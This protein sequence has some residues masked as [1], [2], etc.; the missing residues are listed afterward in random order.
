MAAVRKEVINERKVIP[1]R[2]F[3]SKSH[4]LCNIPLETKK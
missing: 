4:I 3:F 1:L 2:D